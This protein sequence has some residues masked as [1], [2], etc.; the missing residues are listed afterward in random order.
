MNSITHGSVFLPALRDDHRGHLSFHSLIVDA[1][2]AA[3]HLIDSFTLLDNVNAMTICFDQDEQ[4]A[5]R[6]LL[7][8]RR[9]RMPAVG[10][11][12]TFLSSS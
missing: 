7:R 1:D 10:S 9:L 11:F 12:D 2:R 8:R 3:M 5:S 4:L 6:S